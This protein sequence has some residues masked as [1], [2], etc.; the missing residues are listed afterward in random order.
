MAQHGR[1]EL[2]QAWHEGKA[3]K[4]LA[5]RSIVIHGD[6]GKLAC[7]TIV[8]P[9]STA[10]SQDPLSSTSRST[11]SAVAVLPSLRAWLMLLCAVFL[12]AGPLAVV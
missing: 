4:T 1:T 8:C 9:A 5:F 10:G 2:R 12:A 3:W 7:A 11:S 6:S